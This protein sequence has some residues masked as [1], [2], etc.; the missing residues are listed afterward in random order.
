MDYSQNAGLKNLTISLPESTFKSL[1]QEATENCMTAEQVAAW[2]IY[3]AL[4]K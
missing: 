4:K 3:K 1:C 2:I